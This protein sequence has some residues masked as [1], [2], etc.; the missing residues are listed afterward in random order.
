MLDLAGLAGPTP[1]N[2]DFLVGKASLGWFG[3]PT[4]VWGGLAGL[5][6]IPW[7]GVVWQASW[8]YPGLGWSGRPTLVWGGLAGLLGIPWFGVVWQASWAYPGLGWSGRPPGRPWFGAVWQAPRKRRFLPP[9][10]KGEKNDFF[11][12][13]FKKS[14][15]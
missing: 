7:F 1:E 8:A 5:L 13:V 14:A 15:G 10:K 9:L 6:D 3:R 4:L 2:P 11:G 12:G